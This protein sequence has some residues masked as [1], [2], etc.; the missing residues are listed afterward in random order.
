[1]DGAKEDSKVAGLSKH[2]NGFALAEV[3]RE[4]DGNLSGGLCLQVSLTVSP[5]I[6]DV[7]QCNVFLAHD[8]TGSFWVHD[9]L[10]KNTF[11]SFCRLKEDLKKEEKASSASSQLEPPCAI[12][13]EVL[14]HSGKLPVDAINDGRAVFSEQV[15]S[16]SCRSMQFPRITPFRFTEPRK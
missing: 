8:D 4:P 1:M 12:P 10:V 14:F 16:D 13:F 3:N 5:G 11:T 6:I 9:S 7:I 15:L 2:V